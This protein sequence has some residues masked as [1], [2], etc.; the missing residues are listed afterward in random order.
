MIHSVTEKTVIFRFSQ[1]IHVTLQES[2]LSAGYGLSYFRCGGLFHR[3]NDDE[4]DV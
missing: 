1:K 2:V 3:E 4:H